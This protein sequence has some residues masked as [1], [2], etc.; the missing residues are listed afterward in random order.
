VDPEG[1]DWYGDVPNKRCA[2][3]HEGGEVLRSIE[4]DRGCFACML[5]GMDRRKLFMVTTG[6]HGTEDMADGARTSQVLAIEA[7]ARAAG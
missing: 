2:R 5:G 3:V 1:A 4:L 7:P 6:R